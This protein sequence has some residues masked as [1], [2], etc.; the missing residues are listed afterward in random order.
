[1][2]RIYLAS[3]AAARKWTMPIKGWKQALNHFAILFE[4]RLPAGLNK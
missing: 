4:G 1:M 2:R 3:A